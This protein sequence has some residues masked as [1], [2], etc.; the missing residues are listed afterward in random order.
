MCYNVDH[1]LPKGAWPTGWMG[2]ENHP[3]L[4]SSSWGPMRLQHSEGALLSNLH[5]GTLWASKVLQKDCVNDLQNKKR[6][7]LKRIEM[8]IRMG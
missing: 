7:F 6:P 1:V 3:T 8:Q 4:H 5:K 2:A